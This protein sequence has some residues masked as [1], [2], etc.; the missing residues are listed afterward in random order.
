L[1][2][3]QPEP[4]P[5]IQVSNLRKSYGNVLAVADVS[6]GIERGE[7]YGLLGPN[8]A[9]KTTTIGVLAGTV[10]ADA[11]E[12]RIDGAA[13]RTDRLDLKA[14]IGYVP[15][16]LALYE[17][18][19]ATDNL[20]FFGMLYG[21]H[22]PRLDAAI[23]GALRLA[24]LTDRAKDLVRSFSGGMKRR[25]NIGA[26]LIHDPDFIILDEPTVGVDP[27]SRNLI[28]ESLEALTA[29]GKTM[30]YTT[31]YMEEVERL[32]RRVAIMDQG[33]VIAEGEV[34]ELHRLL[35]T[36]NLVHI[37]FA[38]PLSEPIHANP[39]I[40]IDGIE[41]EASDRKSL[42][43]Q[44]ADITAGLPKLIAAIAAMGVSVS[45]VETK[46]PTLEQVFL[47]LTGRQL[48]D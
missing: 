43:V 32:C 6:L 17:D 44:M 27:Q 26:S 15:Q 29:R 47:Y 25:L 19:S 33:R 34:S 21:L 37:T 38:E 45:E 16:D 35:P 12:A 5:F 9:G 23:D 31:H 11:G 22:G 30:L 24:A 46:K 8:G 42:L 10:N 40:E 39:G 41:I 36:R 4:A 7:C 18:L 3:R 14:R 1:S 13:I 2:D 20:R 48:R 28:F